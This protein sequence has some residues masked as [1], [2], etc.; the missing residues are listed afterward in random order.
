MRKG[1]GSG[2]RS[3]KQGEASYSGKRLMTK[4]TRPRGGSSR[5]MT[6]AGKSARTNGISMLKGM[7]KTLKGSWG[8]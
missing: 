2:G 8:N 4:Y 3:L 5:T 7:S 1:K 6:I